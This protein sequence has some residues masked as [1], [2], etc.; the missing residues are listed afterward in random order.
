LTTK[1]SKLIA[2]ALLLVVVAAG[3]GYWGF[4]PRMPNEIASYTTQ[5][6]SLLTSWEQTQRTSTLSTTVTSET[7]LWIKVTATKPV[8]YYLALL[9]S[10]RTEPYVQLA[11]EL[12]KLPDLKNATA[13]A[14][15]TY[16][17]LDATN[18]EVKEAFQLMIKGGTPDARDFT[19]TVPNYNAELQ[20]LYWLACQNEF[21]KDDTLVLSIAMVHGL[22]VTMGD[23]EVREAVKKDT[24]DLLKFFRETNEMQKTRGHHQLESYPLEAKVALAWTGNLTPIDGPV[25]LTRYREN[26]PGLEIYQSMMPST[27]TLVKMREIVVNLGLDRDVRRTIA[28]LEYYFYFDRGLTQ[29]SHWEY[30]TGDKE[31]IVDGQQVSNG[32]IHDMNW[33]LEHYL[34]TGKGIG[35]CSVEASWINTLAKSAGYSSTIISIQFR[36]A[37]G[38][39]YGHSHVVFFEP[40]T[41]SWM[42]YERQLEADVFTFSDIPQGPVNMYVFRPPVHQQGYLEQWDQGRL[43]N[44]NSVYLQAVDLNNIVREFTEGVPAPDMSRWLLYT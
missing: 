9:E 8:S 1:G 20:V 3:L 17:V 5:Q 14:K 38:K 25:Q 29:S 36:D 42:A 18:P 19:Y 2:L 26:R 32:Y 22:W 16:L 24:S 28:N 33:M 13:V 6:T 30:T 44:G 31:I 40:A 15:I 10:N 34:Q 7:T 39:F 41:R 23:N 21:K 35:Q 12:R 4:I 37:D 27:R 43:W 11:R